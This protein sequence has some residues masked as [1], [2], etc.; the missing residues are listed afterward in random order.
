M[1]DRHDHALDLID[2]AGDLA[3]SMS[4]EPEAVLAAG[5]R[6]VRRRRM[7][8]ATGVGAMALVGALWLGGPL[9]P[10]A[11]SG[12]TG[13]PAP[14]AI[15]WQQ[16]LE[17]RLFEI[18]P[19]PVHESGRVRWVAQ[20]R[21]GEGDSVPELV[22]TRDGE[23][24]DPIAA[25]EG[26]GEVLLFQTE[27]L[28]VAVWQSPEGSLGERPQWAP[29]G[30]ASQGAGIT[31]DGAELRYSVAEVVPGASGELVDLYWFTEDAAHAASGASVAST[32][33]TIEGT[34]TLVM[35]DE[36]REVWGMAQLGEHAGLLHVEPLV[37][38][39]GQSGWSGE[40]TV[41][42][43]VG[44]LPPG[45]TDPTV[46]IGRAS[47]VQAP[48]GTQ[49]AVMAVTLTDQ[50][51]AETGITLEEA[52]GT[53]TTYTLP[54]TVRFTLDGE[55]HELESYAQDHGRTLDLGSIQLL[56]TAQPRGLELARG[57]SAHLIPADDLVE[58]QA[59]AGL[60]QGSQ[61]IVVAGWEPEVDPEDLRALVGT[62]DEVR[63]MDVQDAYVDALFDGR[64]LVVLALGQDSV[65]EGESVRG[66]GVDDGEEID[67][68]ELE[69]G[70]VELDIGPLS[71]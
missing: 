68:H 45:A 46:D 5:R 39:M 51:T 43:T 65:A 71:G 6:K 36:A 25:Q 47:L 33:L 56:V 31:V 35:L 21:S 18:S 7:S 14:A 66:V 30:F 13:A 50:T 62:D 1:S 64:P 15:G 67:Q 10:F 11:P 70:V 57:E 3:P 12:P 32:V 42:T 17:E 61:V 63:W 69:D 58:G 24:L 16:G 34:Q 8:S 52:D 38:G 37:S 27:G 2:R 60:V 54:Q 20:L 19:D 55:E 59:L 28:S 29:G 53:T 22:L 26:P 9:N 4:V 41:G 48:L 23:Q 40:Q 44:V 49:T